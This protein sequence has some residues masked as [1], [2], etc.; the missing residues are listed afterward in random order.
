MR[1]A[2]ATAVLMLSACMPAEAPAE[3]L[4]WWRLTAI[5]GQPFAARVLIAFPKDRST[6]VGTGPC[7]WFSATRLTEP[8]PT[9]RITGITATEMA[10]DALAEEQRFFAALE[11]MA[12]MGVSITALYM[13]NDAGRRLDFVPDRPAR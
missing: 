7:N 5:D 3:D 8:F 11:E 13:V 12:R 4:Y 9:D 10:C 1:L 6:V 2:V